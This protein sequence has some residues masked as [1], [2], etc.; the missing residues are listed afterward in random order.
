MDELRMSCKERDRLKVMAVLAEGRLKQVEAGGLLRLSVRQVRRLLRRYEREGDAGLVHRSRGRPSNR[1]IPEGTRRRVMALVR[2]HYADFGPTLASE[3]LAE[4]DGIEVSREW[5]RQRMIEAHLRTVRRR[6]VRHHTWRPR[7]PCFGELVQMDTSEHA[8]FEGR[9][10]AEPVL[11]TMIDDATSRVRMRFYPSDTTEANL[12]LLGRYLRRH[13]RP[14]AL[15]E[16]HNSIFHVNRP[17]SRQ[18]ALAGREAETQF[19]RALRELGIDNIPASSPQAKG[20]VERAFGTEQDRLVKELR[21]RGIS[22]IEAA[23]AYL[24]AE[25]IPWRNRRFSVRPTCSVNAHRS[26]RPYDLKAILS[27]QQIRTVTNDYTVRYR[28]QVLQIERRS[29][30]AGLRKAKVMVEQRL[31]GSLKLRWQGRYL[32][33]HRVLP[34]PKTTTTTT[35]STRETTKDRRRVAASASVPSASASPRRPAPD[36]PWRQPFKRSV[37]SG[38]KPD[39]STLR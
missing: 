25:Y 9:A 18:E 28:G 34:R 12:D 32:R 3:K 33:Y 10:E 22:D 27:V 24:D 7:R 26:I 2:R 20:R 35:T 14:L 17:P 8:W 13:G 30:R 6:R 1:R 36:H 29:I 38:G 16:D 39:I 21:L 37:L 15:Y 5:L 11:V 19:G 4:R 23:N 31:D